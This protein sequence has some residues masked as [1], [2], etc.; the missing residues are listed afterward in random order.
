MTD[1]TGKTPVSKPPKTADEKLDQALDQSFPAS[2]PPVQTQPIVHVGVKASE[3][4]KPGPH[5]R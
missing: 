2:D 4:I 5:R 1:K 3:P